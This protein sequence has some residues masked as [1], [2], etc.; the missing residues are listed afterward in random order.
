MI[1][2]YCV[3]VE[4]QFT[5]LKAPYAVWSKSAHNIGSYKSKRERRKEWKKETL[6]H[7]GPTVIWH[8]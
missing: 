8:P 2:D 4:N 6:F 7:I 1:T 5:L 3:I